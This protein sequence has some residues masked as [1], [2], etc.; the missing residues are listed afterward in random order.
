V[1]P[2][3]IELSTGGDDDAGTTASAPD[4]YVV[5]WH[6]TDEEDQAHLAV[7]AAGRKAPVALALP[8]QVTI[9]LPGQNLGTLQNAASSGQDSLEVAVEN[10][11]GV[12]IER[13]V[14]SD[15]ADLAAAVDAAGGIDVLDRHLDGSGAL[16]YLAEPGEDAPVDAVYLRWQ[17]VLDGLLSAVDERPGGV[18]ALPEA[19]R[20][21]FADDTPDM[22]SVPVIDIG[23]GL[24]RPDVAALERLIDQRFVSSA[25]EGIRLV[26]LNGVGE[27]GIGEE[28]ARILVPEGFRLVS[29]G[30]ARDFNFKMTQIVASSREDLPAAERARS[31]IGAG[32][33][34]LGHQPTGLTDVT[35]V[36]GRDFGGS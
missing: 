7:F 33:I 2:Q 36:V 30:N 35:I 23:G 5:A 25:T 15:P 14:A 21:V 4:Q 8:A 28:V 1:T 11:L 10:L 32:R 12:P 34:L 22:A 20:P 17:D 6:V 24:L 13:M 18:A 27:P 3:L 9:N 16:D 19:V 29:S 26:V 31:L